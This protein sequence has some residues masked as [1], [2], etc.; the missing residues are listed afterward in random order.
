MPDRAMRGMHIMIRPSARLA[1]ALVL[2]HILAAIA[3]FATVMP[4]SARV[5]ALGLIL[6]S[7]SFYLARDIF[8]ILPGSWREVL[9]ATDGVSVLLRSGFRL[10]GRVAAGT[11]ITPLFIILGIHPEGRHLP[12]FRIMLP[13]PEDGDQFRRLSVRLRSD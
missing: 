13:H 6:L 4:R 5:L 9:V 7:L 1:T 2:T 8:L 10:T 11:V 12:L 3:V